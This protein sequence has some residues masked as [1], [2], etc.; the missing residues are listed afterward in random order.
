MSQSSGDL[1]EL[2][3]YLQRQ[4]QIAGYIFVGSTSVFI[5]DILNNLRNDYALFFKQKFHVACLAYAVSR[6]ASLMYALGFTVFATYPLQACNTSFVVF[7]VFY[8]IGLSAS[9]F[10]FFF[11]VRAIYSGDR[12]VTAIFGFLWLAVLGASITIPF[13]GSAI[14]LGHPAECVLAHG[15]AYLGAAGIILTVH[16]TLVFFA[17]SYRLVSNFAQTQQQTRGEQLKTLFSG[18]NLPAF[19][20]ALFVDGQMY[21]MITVLINIFATLLVYIPGISPVYRGVMVVPSTTL[22]SIMACR[23]YRN[24]KLGITRGTAELALPTLSSNA[25][26]TIPLSVVQFST[27]PNRTTGRWGG[28]GSGSSGDKDDTL[29][30]SSKANNSGFLP[31]LHHDTGIVP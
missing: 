15:E 23:V 25:V 21:Y 20:K 30:E 11:R 24:T 22:T 1:E 8:P 19:S 27:Q 3:A 10:L 17:I 18:A 12:L 5:W 26:G 29:N 16:D 31:T 2:P 13:G 4:I 6:I 7:N 14:K 28:D 9:A